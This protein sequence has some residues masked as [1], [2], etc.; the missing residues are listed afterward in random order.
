MADAAM[1]NCRPCC[2]RVDS[3]ELILP[4]LH[5]IHASVYTLL[6]DLLLCRDGAGVPRVKIPSRWRVDSVVAARSGLIFDVS[7]I[8]WTD[9]KQ[10]KLTS[11][12]QTSMQRTCVLCDVVVVSKG[13]LAIAEL[14]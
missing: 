11:R 7:R 8:K 1:R 14:T 9:K 4:A 3:D 6:R 2:V 12:E 10:E 13:K 5:P